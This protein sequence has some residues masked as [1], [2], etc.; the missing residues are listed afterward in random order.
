MAAH[1]LGIP[2]QEVM[3]RS[4]VNGRMQIYGTLVR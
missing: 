3:K 2:F 4:M 1:L